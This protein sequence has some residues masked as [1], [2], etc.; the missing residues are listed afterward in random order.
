MPYV[1]LD[2]LFNCCYPFWNGK[3]VYFINIYPWGWLIEQL[4]CPP[5]IPDYSIW[6]ISRHQMQLLLYLHDAV[7]T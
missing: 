4:T 7:A 2:L 6:M 3:Y 1:V 5:G